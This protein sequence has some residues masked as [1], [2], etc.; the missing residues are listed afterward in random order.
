MKLNLGGQFSFYIPGHPRHVEVELKEA[1]R[2]IDVLSRLGIPAAEVHLV[3]I[4]GELVELQE[5]IVTAA[6][7]VKLFPPVNGG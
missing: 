4:N 2:L 3:V 7:E 6:D 1:A 5:A